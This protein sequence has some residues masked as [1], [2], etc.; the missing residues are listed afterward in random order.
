MTLVLRDNE[1]IEKNI[2]I[3]TIHGKGVLYITNKSVVIVIDKKGLLFE[4]LHTE[5]ASII[6]TEKNKIKLTWPENNNL[7]DFTFRV[8]DAQY[9]INDILIHHSYD[10]NFPDIT[11]ASHI[12]YGDNDI[13]KIIESRIKHAEQNI[14]LVSKEIKIAETNVSMVSNA[15]NKTDEKIEKETKINTIYGKGILYITSKSVVI[16]I[17]KKGLLFERLH[18]QMASIISTEKNKIKLTWP[19]NNNL[20]DFIFRVNDAQCIVNDILI[21]HSYDDNFPDIMG[22]SHV[23]YGDGDIKKIIESRI[24]HAERNIS[25]VSKEIKIAETNVSMIS[26]TVNKTDEKIL[27]AVGEK[28]KLEVILKNWNQYISDIPKIHFNRSKKIPQDIPNHLCWND[29]YHNTEHKCYVT[30]NEYWNVDFFQDE[31]S[32]RKFS[33]QN[34]IASCY[35]IPDKFVTYKNGYPI[36][37]KESLKKLGL[38]K[39][40][41]IP[42]FTDSMLN[43]KIISEKHGVGI[44]MINESAVF[45]ESYTT[46]QTSNGSKL[47]LD[48]KIKSKYTQKETAFLRERKTIPKEDLGKF[49]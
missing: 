5:M 23:M 9:I 4:R 15:V 30:F 2:K 40:P 41:Y 44:E 14:S 42:T 24:R 18:T 43:D 6:S 36:L 33:T 3:S 22:A 45:C 8:N 16:V 7:F 29:V 37:V 20:F 21:H 46:Y 10:D 31:E 35:A 48:D 49:S 28:T 17:D 13:K 47:T 32:V 27:E 19:E 38:T 1:K 34:R 25:S 39:T 11:G 26:N 12:M